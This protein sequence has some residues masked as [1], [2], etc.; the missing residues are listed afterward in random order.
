MWPLLLALLAVTLSACPTTEGP[1]G[2]QGP[3]G[4][5]GPAGA[6]G[7]AGPQGPPGMVLVVDGGVVTGPMGPA[8][9]SVRVSAVAPGPEC[10]AGG[11]RVA[12][13]DGG[14][15]QVVCHGAP[16]VAGPAGSA[17]ASVQLQAVDGGPC[18][19]GGVLLSVDG[20]ASVFLCHGAPGPAGAQGLQGPVGAAGPQGPAGP[21]G[22]PGP[23][24]VSLLPDGG[25]ASTG[26]PGDPSDGVTFAGY[27]TATYTG[28]L[29]GPAGANQ[30]CHAEF[31]GAHLCTDR[32]FLAVGV[33]VPVPA[34]GVWVEP[35]RWPSSTYPGA[36]L[37]DRAY[38]SSDCSG[39]DYA[40]ADADGLALDVTG[41][42]API[43][44]RA[45]NVPHALACCRSP[46]AWFRGFTAQSYSGN[47]GGPAGAHQKCA[48]EFPRSHLCTD[49]EY[50]H[51][52]SA[53]PIPAGGVWV[54]PARY[55]SSTS[56]SPSVRDRAFNSSDCS[57]WDYALGDADGLVLDVT[58]LAAPIVTRGC[59][60]FHRLACCGL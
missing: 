36:T 27:T 24:G 21:A 26:Y 43:T 47:L 33:S 9:A 58:G 41:L 57:G 6:P 25:F 18:A 22:P 28:N 38:N 1:A 17:G 5:P 42:A 12:L 49:R 52:G 31:P 44:S 37:R 29:G 60:T 11:V 51:A 50:L 39:W 59:N 3:K 48:A 30:K 46:T 56:P 10:A 15:A 40:Q 4:D 35:G 32:E 34:G 13:E 23:P 55:P 7:P 19:S 53:V 8:G 14:A 54:E 2:P 45:C 20:G 16:G